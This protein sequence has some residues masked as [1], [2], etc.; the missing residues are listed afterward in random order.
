MAIELPKG[1]KPAGDF[2]FQVVVGAIMFTVIAMVA[3]A[4]AAFV[5]WMET[6]G[7]APEWLL[8]GLHWVEWAIFWVDVL[9]FGLFLTAEV[10][11]LIRAFWRDWIEG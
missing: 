10:L 7:V 11:K 8:E 1:L 4:L 5:K 9:C 6:W 3:V 2:C